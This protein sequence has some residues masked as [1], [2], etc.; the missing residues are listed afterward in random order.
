MIRHTQFQ[1]I[2]SFLMI[3]ILMIQF[4]GCYSYKIISS[5]DLPHPNSYEY[6]FI[7]FGQNSRYVL[8]NTVISNGIFSGKINSDRQNIKGKI[9]VY[10]SSD[11]VMKINPENILSVPLDGI[12]KVEIKKIETGNTVLLTIAGL[13]LGFIT[14]VIIDVA[15]NGFG[16]D[17][18]LGGK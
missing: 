4:S 7:I 18:N 8:E 6:T 9:N 12:V 11:T 14:F 5:S 10:L 16:I 3:F 2:I 1:K 13:V 17:I 15:I